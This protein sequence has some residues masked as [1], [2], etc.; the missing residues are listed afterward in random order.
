MAGLTLDDYV[1]DATTRD[2]RTVR[3]RPIR[4]SDLDSMLEMWSRLSAETIRMRFF[5]PMHM[6]RERMRYFTEVDFDERVALVAERGERIVGVARFDR[7]PGRPERAEFAVLVEDAEQG[8]GI[9]T[10]LL[11]ALAA[12]AD[13]LGVTE[14]HGDVLAENRRLLRVLRDAGLAP[15]IHTDGSVVTTNFRATA[16]QD[17]L[18]AGDEHD[19]KAAVAALRSVLEP[20][21]IAVVGASRDPSTIGGLVFDNLRAGRFSG[22]V[23]PVNHSADVVQ[24]VAAYPSI[25]DCPTTPG[26]VIVCVPAEAVCE[27]VEEAGRA[28]CSVVVIVSAGFGE[29]G[30][31]GRKRQAD[32]VEVARRYGVRLIGPNCMGVLN[33]APAKRMNATFSPNFPAAGNVAFSSQSGALGLAI[34]GAAQRLGIGL[35]TFVSVGNKADISGN[36]LVQY[37]EV[38]DATDVILLYLE[39]FGNPG[40]FGR[41]ARRVGRTKPIAVV[42][43][44]RTSAGERA[45]SGHTGA[46]AAGDLAVDALFRQAGVIRTD[47]LEQLFDVSV[48]LSNGQIPETNRVAIVTNGGGPGILAADACESNGLELPRP[49]ERTMARLR[50]FL[51]RG[52]S[53]TNPVDMIASASAEQY[54]RAVET[55]ADDPHIDTVISIFIPPIVTTAAD[56][57]QALVEARARVSP[58]VSLLNVFMEDSD[59]GTIL[60]DAGLPTFRYPEDAAV[61]LARVA[62]YGQ[63]CRR[64]EGEVVQVEGA[65]SADARAVVDAA[66]EHADDLWL[67]PEDTDR[68]LNAYG[69]G[70][71]G[72]VH[73]KTAEEAVRAWEGIGGPVA[74]KLAAAT[75]KSDV[76]GVKLGLDGADAVEQAVAQIER[77]VTDHGQRELLDDGYVVQEMVPEGVELIAGVD[78]HPTFGHLLLVGLGG[79]LVELL[80]DVSVRIHPL[81]D[82]D[83]D[84]MLTSLRGFPLLTGYRGSEPVDLTAVKHLLFRLSS[85]VEDVPEVRELDINPV[86]AGTDGVRAV[87]A[88]IR[89]SRA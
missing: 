10:A 40:K 74:V 8:H 6:N 15:G 64:P 49:T 53:V 37:W 84:E 34:L 27:I 9:G 69:I 1:S 33:A 67:D 77:D 5:A 52:A 18:A 29:L 21:T 4:E 86:F 63:W 38:D 39:S 87:D 11:R 32:V 25:A 57:A 68:L 28:G 75:H 41:I 56:V 35:S 54:R 58:G 22:A 13:A 78:Y 80:G 42:K 85:L 43:A 89:L 20:E 3:I 62:R 72:F 31:E 17:F 60:R 50:S 47:T 55:I 71:A 76:G 2:G 48:L 14:F 24:T 30:E 19:R 12:P 59:A 83:V 79:T 26:L 46:L 70:T 36:D 65:D 7:D 16:T 61:A 81:T 66:L 88:R 45:A 44:G 73:V 23:Y 82:R 51:P